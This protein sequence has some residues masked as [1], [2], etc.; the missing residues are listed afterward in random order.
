MLNSLRNPP[1]HQTTTAERD[2]RS[3]AEAR[4]REIEKR[5]DGLNGEACSVNHHSGER[6]AVLTTQ[7]AGAAKSQTTPK[8]S[9]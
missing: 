8:C 2:V 6:V 1:C 7:L 3:E 4:A 5:V 9:G